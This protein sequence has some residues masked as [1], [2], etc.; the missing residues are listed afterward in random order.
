[1]DLLL[2]HLF[3]PC[4]ARRSGPD[5]GSAARLLFAVVNKLGARRPVSTTAGVGD[6]I[7]PAQPWHGKGGGNQIRS[8]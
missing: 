1:M 5:I 6:G 2:G 4:L 8:I 7:L 3:F